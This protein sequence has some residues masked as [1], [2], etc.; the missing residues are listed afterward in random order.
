MTASRR[1]LPLFL[2]VVGFS[3]FGAAAPAD[4]DAKHVVVYWEKGRFGGW[5]ANHGMWCWGN[6]ILV[7]FSR[8]W[9]K[10]LGPKRHHFDREKP[11]EHW[12][13]RS[14]D[15]GE[16][17]ALEHPAEKGQLIPRGESLHGVETPGVAIPELQDCPGG[18]PFTHPDFAMTLRMSSVDA[19]VSRFC[20]ST[21]RGHEWKG[22]FR[23]PDF[24][25][26][27]TAARTDYLVDG[28][29]ACTALLTAAKADG[30]EGVPFCARTTD[31]GKTWAMVSRL[32][33][34]PKGYAIMPASVRLGPEE[35]YTVIRERDDTGAWLSAYRTLDNGK[36]WTREKNPV[37]DCGE[38]NPG[39]LV[40][41]PDGRLCLTYAVRKAPFRMCAKVSADRGATWSPELVLRDD[42]ANRDIGYSQSVVRPDGRVVT[43][44]YF[45]TEAMGPERGIMATLWTPPPAE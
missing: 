20:Y 30:K 21:D 5:P 3:C 23:L 12:L 17:W 41:L 31:G 29:D 36:A 24:G 43:T 38:G 35:I 34:D 14:L 4:L 1:F 42:G 44:Y 16:T 2:L 28:P 45:N 9:Y 39:D 7:G 27:G 6:E 19:G 13:A 26:K 18:V 32:M 15:G 40:A 22:P 25:F 11:E 8:G 37:D 33:K 10:D